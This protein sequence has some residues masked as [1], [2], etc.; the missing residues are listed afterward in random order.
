MI[1]PVK[2]SR[3]HPTK[4]SEGWVIHLF[5]TQTTVPVPAAGWFSFL[6]RR[7]WLVPAADVFFFQSFGWNEP[8]VSACSKE[9]WHVKLSTSTM[10]QKKSTKKNY[11]L[12][13]KEHNFS[14]HQIC[15]DPLLRFLSS[16][17][18]FS[19]AFTF[20][21]LFCPKCFKPGSGTPH[22]DLDQIRAW[23]CSPI[24]SVVIV[25]SDSCVFFGCMMDNEQFKTR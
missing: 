22:L 16:I 17:C 19:R 23:K 13:S 5:S 15:T 2:D 12:A 9:I 20:L 24:I 11:R 21:D 18:S 7:Q 25:V 3:T 10:P 6:Q 14:I 1:S 4:T 8:M